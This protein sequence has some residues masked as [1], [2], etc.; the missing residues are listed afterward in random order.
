MHTQGEPQGE[1][2]ASSTGQVAAASDPVDEPTHVIPDTLP[3]NF[4]QE[5]NG[6]P[7][8]D[9]DPIESLPEGYAVDQFPGNDSVEGESNA[10]IPSADI[11]DA[12][13]SDGAA[14]GDG[15]GGGGSFVPSGGFGFSVPGQAQALMSDEANEDSGEDTSLAALDTG[16]GDMG[17]PVD[18]FI[19]P[20]DGPES[21][22][23]AQ[24]T[25]PSSAPEAQEGGRPPTSSQGPD[26]FF[27]TPSGPDIQP[28]PQTTDGP[29]SLQ[30]INGEPNPPP[31][32]DEPDSPSI[33]S[34]PLSVQEVPEPGSIGLIGLG[35]LGMLWIRKSRRYQAPMG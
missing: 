12:D 25:P 32:D 8:P 29:P 27:L 17:D 9:G 22:D 14:D 1:I 26:P 16:D 2:E 7:T 30:E 11:P 19:D 34:V 15:A 21:F 28:N 31:S 20:L 23:T 4:T 18:D 35:L 5:S 3:E 6:S 24:F 10:L 33:R 13:D